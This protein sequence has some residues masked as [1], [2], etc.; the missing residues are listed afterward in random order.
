MGKD[1]KP[2][3]AELKPVI[4]DFVRRVSKVYFPNG[5]PIGT[6]FSTLEDLACQ[7][8]DEAS[9]LIM[10]MNVQQ[11]AEN[12]PE[13]EIGECPLCGGAARK[14]PDE[15]R[16]L[17]TSRGDVDWENRVLNCPRCRRAFFPSESSIGD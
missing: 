14:K 10:E 9:R 6:K 17:K 5:M 4:A 3:P 2:I 16:T 15:P 1:A 8:G 12:W 11:Q 7:V 13:D